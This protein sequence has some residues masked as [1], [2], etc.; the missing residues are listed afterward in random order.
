M[1]ASIGIKKTLQIVIQFP[2]LI[3][4]PA[5][6]QWVIAPIESYSFTNLFCG[7][8]SRLGVSFLHTWINAGITLVGQ[9]FF[10]VI[11]NKEYLF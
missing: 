10:L 5:F 9:Y 2:A 8:S 4:T 1:G 6:S 3:L 7:G 11:R